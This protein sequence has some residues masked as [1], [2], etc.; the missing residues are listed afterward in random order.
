MIATS[1]R[2]ISATGLIRNHQN[3]VVATAAAAAAAQALVGAPT[4]TLQQPCAAVDVRIVQH[5]FIHIMNAIMRP[6]P[7]MSKLCKA[8]RARSLLS[9]TRV[10]PCHMLVSARHVP[11]FTA[12]IPWIAVEYS[13]GVAVQV[14]L[15]HSPVLPIGP[16][17]AED[18]AGQVAGAIALDGLL[19]G[20]R[21]HTQPPPV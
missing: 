4:L 15:Q 17:H 9:A 12:P 18:A 3:V 8:L 10:I 6:H 14:R 21:L 7:T 11:H 5:G 13:E 1:E 2:Y 19:A 20:V 16:L